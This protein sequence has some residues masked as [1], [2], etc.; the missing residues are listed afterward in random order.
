MVSSRAIIWCNSRPLNGVGRGRDG[1]TRRLCL[2]HLRFRFFFS[3]Q[4]RICFESACLCRE[5]RAIMIILAEI[6]CCTISQSI[7]LRLWHYSHEVAVPCLKGSQSSPQSWPTTAVS[8]P[9]SRSLTFSSLS[10]C[11]ILRVYV[12]SPS[13]AKSLQ[14]GRLRLLEDRA[15]SPRSCRR[16][17]RYAAP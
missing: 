7:S 16:F 6:L 17:A 1:G 13:S 12:L 2:L 15:D 3:L 5:V 10:S 8:V 11:R 9:S 14:D 4:P